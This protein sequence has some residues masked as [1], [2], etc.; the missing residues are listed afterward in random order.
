M[1]SITLLG[2]GPGN[3][4]QLTREAWEVLTQADEIYLRTGKHPTVAGFPP[5]LKVHTFDH[6][7]E[8]ADTFE[9]VY[10]RIVESVLEL[11]QRPQGVVYAVPGHPFVAE[12]TGREIA[13]RAREEGIPLRVVEGLSFLEPTF[14]AL[15]QDAFPKTALADALELAALHVPPFPPAAPALVA[16]LYDRTVASE[17]KLTLM[18]VY[19]DEHQVALVHA[20]GT[21]DEVVRWMPLYEIDRDPD[22]GLLTSLYIPALSPDASFEA[23]QEVVARLRAP[24]GCPWDRKQTHHSLRKYLLEETYE[25]LEAI[26]AEDWD[27]LAEELG[28]VLLQVLL[29]AQIAFE[30]GEFTMTEV[31]QRIHRK[32][33]RRHPH[34][35]GDVQVADADE[36]VR[37]WEAIKAQE[38]GHAAPKGVLDGITKGLPA[39]MEAEEIQK[40]VVK[41]GFDW[42]DIQ[43]VWDKLAE[44]LEEVRQ[45]QTPEE[46]A[47]EIGDVLFVV[48]NLARWLGVNAELALR[49]ANARFRRRFAAIERAA[50]EQGRPVDALTLDEME[51]VWQQAKQEENPDSGV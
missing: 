3:P 9:M 10:Q 29:H 20:A 23:F 48:V 15:G 5:D 31:L 47:A 44:E 45:A 16:Q 6:L 43:G 37:N 46:K 30:E 40:K 1:P 4:N 8:Q 42:P 21:P 41:V 24:D 27:A 28:D 26:D 17:V 7:Y 18:A 49:E 39:L 51:A 36:V 11:A 12:I 38:K 19:P 2:L 32:M 14:R 34:V 35:F 50:R 13:R 22:I 25:V 33:V